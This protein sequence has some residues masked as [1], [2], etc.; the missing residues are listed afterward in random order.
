LPKSQSEAQGTTA[1][2][3]STTLSFLRRG[4]TGLPAG[5]SNTS[6]KLNPHIVN[7][8]ITQV[9]RALFLERWLSLS[10]D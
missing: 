4:K 1:L 8:G 6:N 10:Q 3:Y 9:P 5:A 2:S 7:A